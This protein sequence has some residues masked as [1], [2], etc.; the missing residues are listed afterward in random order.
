MKEAD[1]IGTGMG[2]PWGAQSRLGPQRLLSCPPYSAL[3]ALHFP[4]VKGQTQWQERLG[5]PEPWSPSPESEGSDLEQ[6]PWSTNHLI[7]P[8]SACVGPWFQF[9]FL[10]AESK[11]SG[12]P[13]GAQFTCVLAI[14]LLSPCM[15]TDDPQPRLWCIWLKARGLWG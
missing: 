6:P 14:L 13:E 7:T 2:F 4:T 5:F 3:P 1:L 8:P 10:P 12:Y 11:F 9:Y 15:G